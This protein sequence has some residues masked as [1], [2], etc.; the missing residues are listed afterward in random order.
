MWS[1]YASSSVPMSEQY[2][3]AVS[4]TLLRFPAGLKPGDWRRL[5]ELAWVRCLLT[6]QWTEAWIT[7][8]AVIV[9]IEPGS[10]FACCFF[11]R[12]KA[13]DWWRDCT[14]LVG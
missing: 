11:G 13:K 12:L 3:E 6:A 10:T 8:L 14:L 4:S 1:P 9:G 5:A 7:S 2:S